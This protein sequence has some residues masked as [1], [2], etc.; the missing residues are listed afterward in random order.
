[1]KTFQEIVKNLFK[2]KS[3]WSI[4][5]MVMCLYGV[6]T[7]TIPAEIISMIIGSI[8]AYYFNKREES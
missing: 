8:I 4:T 6:F 1:M 3:L 2:I 5:A 7:D